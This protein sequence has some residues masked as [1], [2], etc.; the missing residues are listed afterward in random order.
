MTALYAFT[1]FS[2]ACLVLAMAS[3]LGLW[4]VCWGIEIWRELRGQ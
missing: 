3:L 2:G 1:I 4:A